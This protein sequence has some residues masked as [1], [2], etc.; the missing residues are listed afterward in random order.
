ME[1]DAIMSAGFETHV[2]QI[3]VLT[4]RDDQAIV[5]DNLNAHKGEGIGQSIEE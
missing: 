4:L 3:L 1:G 5:M 2:Q